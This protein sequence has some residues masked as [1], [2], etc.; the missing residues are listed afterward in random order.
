MNITE[1][2]FL[3][4]VRIT[5]ILR[6]EFK[7]ITSLELLGRPE[8]DKECKET[9]M[10][11]PLVKPKDQHIALVTYKG[12]K[13]D[14]KV[15]FSDNKSPVNALHKCLKH[16]MNVS[17][18]PKD[19]QSNT[20]AKIIDRLNELDAAECGYAYLVKFGVVHDGDFDY[21]ISQVPYPTHKK[22]AIAAAELTKQLGIQN[23]RIIGATAKD[24]EKG[25]VVKCPISRGGNGYQVEIQA[26]AVFPEKYGV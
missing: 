14:I 3:K 10:E 22:A 21:G 1:K 17:F 11:Y 18:S 25:G 2:Q 15:A 19:K 13:N 7:R 23:H 26:Y 9:K 6:S 4:L 16:L 5:Q 24:F 8:F 12:K 20:I